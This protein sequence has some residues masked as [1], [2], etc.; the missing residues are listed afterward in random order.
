MLLVTG[1][2]LS[3]E[4]ARSSLTLGLRPGS[5][6]SLFLSWQLPFLDKT[7]VPLLRVQGWLLANYICLFFNDCPGTNHLCIV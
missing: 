7:L 4:A 1:I 6:R 5:E 2:S 3:L